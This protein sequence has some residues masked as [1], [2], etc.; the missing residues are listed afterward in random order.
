MSTRQNSSEQD[1]QP[2]SGGSPILRFFLKAGLF[3]VGLG[4]CG[5]L[6]AGMALALALPNLPDLHAMTGLP[7]ARAAARPT[8]PTA[9]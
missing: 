2:D 9:C 5:A 7:A 6:L 8:R 4:L 1:Q 3:C